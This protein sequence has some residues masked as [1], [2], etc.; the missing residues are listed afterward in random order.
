MTAEQIIAI[1]SKEIGVC[2]N[3]PTSN[4]VKYNTWFYDGPVSGASYPWC[5]TFISWVF[6]GTGLVPKTAS[7][8]NMLAY[9]EGTNQIVKNP[10]AGDLV[11]F[12]FATNNR[13][14]NHVGLVISV[15]GDTI[16]TIEG[17]TSQTSQDNGGK[18]LK[19]TRR[20]NI[21]AYVRPKYDG[22]SVVN[23]KKRKTI[24]LGS[25]G[26]DV[27][28]LQKKL[29]DH[30]YRVVI[31]GTFGPKTQDAVIRFQTDH[32]LMADGIVGPKTWA[33]IEE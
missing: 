23:M 33:R 12:K 24:R 10:K 21:V 25:R 2:E 14:T 3:P 30:G 13:R 19:R 31:D 22:T 32:Q 7:C 6:R 17:N 27:I 20:S 16:T 26:D 15:N 4:N 11:F 1:A 18:V 28:Y 9:Y 5:A 29:T 8:A